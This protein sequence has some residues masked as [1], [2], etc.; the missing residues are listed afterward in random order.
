MMQIKTV[1]K[2]RKRRLIAGAFLLSIF[3]VLFVLS[4]A[5]YADDGTENAEEIILQDPGVLPDSPLFFF[6]RAGKW[7]RLNVLTFNPVKKAEL[8][9]QIAEERLAELRAL[10]QKST[11]APEVL[12]RAETRLR[13]RTQELAQNISALDEAGRDVSAATERLG[14]LALKEQAVL[15]GVLERVPER[16]RPRI[17]L[18][19]E[20]SHAGLATARDVIVRQQKKTFVAEERLEKFFENSLTQLNQQIERRRELIENVADEDLKA[21][22]L[23]ELE[24]KIE[25]AE[26]H[27]LDIGIKPELRSVKARLEAGKQPSLARI[28][29]LRKTV[30][31]RS[32]VKEELLENALAASSTPPSE[33]FAALFK[34]VDENIS[35][36][37]AEI[38]RL[39]AEGREVPQNLLSLLENGKKH[40]ADA[41]KENAG[42]D[43]HAVL[44]NLTAADRN[45]NAAMRHL[46]LL[47]E[48]VAKK[49]AEKRRTERAVPRP[50]SEEIQSDTKETKETTETNAPQ[51][52]KLRPAPS[53]QAS[54]ETHVI[55]VINGEFQPSELKIRKGDV[56]TWVND[57]AD[58]GA[59]PASA[60]HPTHT[61]YPGSA[62]GKCRTPERKRIFDACGA[63]GN[64]EQYSF[65]FVIPGAWNYHDHL[66][67]S[68]RGRVVV[69]E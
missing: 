56:V 44:G 41:K 5:A 14:E 22:M 65:T 43:S 49:D 37:E 19:L 6:D 66:H 64:G 15:E 11:V 47:R 35:M 21:E 31:L 30:G 63:L 18:A 23:D 68:V 40:L 32:A 48:K 50:P 10:A 55:R 53:A 60:V 7:L 4:P 28:L 1:D 12:E 52:T 62:I 34:K 13:E 51:D 54:P 9:S 2:P 61:A 25:S 38:Q 29:T 8:R 36:L 24:R 45:V 27:A 26:A 69:A 33:I 17:Q 58:R 67:P 20:S 59:W 39:N 42:A 57:T 46:R 16:V 3:S